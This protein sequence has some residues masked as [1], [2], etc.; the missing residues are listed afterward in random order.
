MHAPESQRALGLKVKVMCK[1]W[2]YRGMTKAGCC[3]HKPSLSSPVA[4]STASGTPGFFSG[5]VRWGEGQSMQIRPKPACIVE[6]S[7]HTP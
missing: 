3:A 2:R 1:L 7:A 6:L 4:L 5:T